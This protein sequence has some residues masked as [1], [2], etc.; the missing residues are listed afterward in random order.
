L[1]IP[2]IALAAAA[3]IAAALPAPA[4][5]QSG[6]SEAQAAA[7]GTVT[8]KLDVTRFKATK[9]GPVAKGTATATLRGLGG[10]PAT[11]T[12]DVTL[13]QARRGGCRILSLVLDELDLTLLGVNV[14]LDK[15]NLRVTGR[16]RGG[17]LGR[18]FCGLA[19]ARVSQA[20]A[21]ATLNRR[22]ERGG[23]IRP[24]R[25]TVPVQ[26]QT[27]QATTCPILEL[28][29]GP[30]HLDLLG[31]VVDLNRVHLT[32]TAIRG[33]GILGDLLCGLSSTTP[34]VP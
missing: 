11:V 21:V 10:A 20:R 25:M 12:Q 32:I 24:F 13:A 22:L 30:L 8:V 29:L 3:I 6:S 34:T 33:G 28:T 27:A 1:R 31:L 4:L 16:R 5:A 15:V 9:A 2:S 7:A 18:L 19:G 23:A 26:A 17:V 14:H